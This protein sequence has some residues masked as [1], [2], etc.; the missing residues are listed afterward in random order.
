LVLF[1][2][3]VLRT[4]VIFFDAATAVFFPVAVVGFFTVRVDIE[5]F[6]AGAFF[7]VVDLVMG[8]F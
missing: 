2:L 6:V 1:A 5:A 3:E 4:V 8:V 7:V